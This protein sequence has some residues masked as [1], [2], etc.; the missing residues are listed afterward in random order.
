MNSPPTQAAQRDPLNFKAS[1]M[2]SVGGVLSVESPMGT[3]ISLGHP[4]Y[5]SP[6]ALLAVQ[7]W[8]MQGSAGVF[9]MCVCVFCCC[10]S[11]YVVVVCVCVY[12]CTHIPSLFNEACHTLFHTYHHTRRPPS[13]TSSLASAHSPLFC[14]CGYPPFSHF[15]ASSLPGVFIG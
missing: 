6:Q 2:L 8:E 7:Q 1:N 12:A 3:P 9:C 14:T 11:V 5:C 15:E 13:S 4:A 10:L